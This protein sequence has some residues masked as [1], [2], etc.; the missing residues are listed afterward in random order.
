MEEARRE[1]IYFCNCCRNTFADAYLPKSCPLCGADSN[2]KPNKLPLKR[3]T[4]R[5][6]RGLV[7][8]QKEQQHGTR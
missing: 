2:K 4:H 1:R 8:L 3:V 6:R 7:K 5:Q